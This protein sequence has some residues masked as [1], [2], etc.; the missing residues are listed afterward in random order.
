MGME[1][2]QA[3]SA[4]GTF[5]RR[6]QVKALLPSAGRS[7]SRQLIDTFNGSLFVQ[8]GLFIGWVDLNMSDFFDILL[9]YLICFSP[10]QHHCY[11]FVA[12]NER[13]QNP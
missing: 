2:T 12:K 1:Q 11:T 3:Y 10:I 8:F 5:S 13:W 9:F 4:C 6:T 7:V